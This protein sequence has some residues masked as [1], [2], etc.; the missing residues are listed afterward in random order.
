MKYI[1][2]H[3]IFWNDYLILEIHYLLDRQLNCGISPSSDTWHSSKTFWKIKFFSK[4]I[5][6]RKLERFSDYSEYLAVLTK[7]QSS[8]N[9]F[10]LNVLLCY[11]FIKNDSSSS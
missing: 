1:E 10:I 2:L 9:E 5:Y 4:K 11:I 6:V 3:T 7:I 8:F